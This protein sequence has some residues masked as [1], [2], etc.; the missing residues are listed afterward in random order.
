MTKPADDKL[1]H[2]KRE[3]KALKV[4]IEQFKKNDQR[5]LEMMSGAWILRQKAD[6]IECAVVHATEIIDQMG[7]QGIDSEMATRA[8]LETAK[9]FLQFADEAD[10]AEAEE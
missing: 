7:Y 8:V 9:A 10:K 3:I 1:G 5:R 6:A 2:A 4:Q